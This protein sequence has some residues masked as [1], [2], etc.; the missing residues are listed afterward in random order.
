V[1]RLSPS[2]K[3]F[4]GISNKEEFKN[5]IKSYI[6]MFNNIDNIFKCK[7]VYDFILP[8]TDEGTF[9]L[10]AWLLDS[11]EKTIAILKPEKSSPLIDTPAEVVTSPEVDMSTPPSEPVKA[12]PAP[13]PKK[14]MKGAPG[15]PVAAPY[16]PFPLPSSQWALAPKDAPPVSFAKRMQCKQGKHTTHSPTRCGIHLTLPAGSQ[17]TT[18]SF[19]PAVIDHLNKLIGEDLHRNLCLTFAH[20][21]SRGIL[22]QATCTPTSQEISFVLRHVRKIFPSENSKH[23]TKT[24]VLSMS[25]LKVLDVHTVG[26]NCKTWCQETWELFKQGLKL[27][28]ASQ[29][30][31]N[32]IKNSLHVMC[33]SRNS[34]TCT[35]WVD[36]HNMVL[37]PQLF[38]M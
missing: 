30:L 33:N 37:W 32:H 11:L 20:M 34:D 31:A 18:A 9:V 8:G 22:L 38:C 6:I 27:S 4:F 12:K 25:Y 16:F 7:E 2:I 5:E 23:I 3:E 1:D 14:D 10:G 13:P 19:I 28:L 24:Q 26:S 36:I 15:K 21:A 29:K 35:V 17:I